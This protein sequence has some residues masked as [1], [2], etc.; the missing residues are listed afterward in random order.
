VE[1][2]TVQIVATVTIDDLLSRATTSAADEGGGEAAPG[3]PAP[4]RVGSIEQRIR[5]VA[6]QAID[7]LNVG[8]QFSEVSLTSVFPPLRV[9]PDFQNVNRVD[10]DASKSREDA[11]ETRRRRLNEVAGSAYRPLLDLIDQYETLLN[12]EETDKAEPV[13]DEIFAVFR[14][15]RN[16]RNVTIGGKPY[17]DV[18]FAGKAA[19]QISNARRTRQVVVDNAKRRASLYQAKLEQ[20]RAN[21]I[22]FLAR[23]WS[24]AM[25]QFLGSKQVQSFFVPST[26]EFQ[27]QLNNDPDIV[28]E[29]QRE[30]Q[31]QRTEEWLRRAGE[32]QK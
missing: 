27:L 21:P 18:T 17:A 6:Q 20:Y 31:K 7:K 25:R 16:G 2:A 32:L 10:S 12:A 22:A 29:L 15:D 30:H 3:A 4:A 11:E 26:G 1:R 28:R 23:E 14:G 5:S 8:I 9:R 13:L 24:D 19:E